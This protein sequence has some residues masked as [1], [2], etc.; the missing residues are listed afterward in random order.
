MNR[1]NINGHYWTFVDGDEHNMTIANDLEC[2][3]EL[4]NFQLHYGAF[5]AGSPYKPAKAM[6]MPDT[7][8]INVG[9]YIQHREVKETYVEPSLLARISAWQYK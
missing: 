3:R 5:E 2:E 4:L 1:D 8:V 9:S 6:A 7:V